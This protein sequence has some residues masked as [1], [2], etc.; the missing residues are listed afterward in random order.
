MGRPPDLNELAVPK[1]LHRFAVPR[2]NS[3]ARRWNRIDRPRLA[4][5][6]ALSPPENVAWFCCQR[7]QALEFVRGG[8]ILD[9]P[10]IFFK[11]RSS[12]L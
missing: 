5:R 7:G 6:S 10:R 1:P 2:A 8:P 9:G 12:V 11:R 3:V 4:L